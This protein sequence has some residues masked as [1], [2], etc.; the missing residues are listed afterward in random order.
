M[1]DFCRKRDSNTSRAKKETNITAYAT[2]KYTNS[3]R[4]KGFKNFNKDIMA[5]LDFDAIL[6]E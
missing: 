2:S 4:K 3:T 5:Y 1:L 6:Q